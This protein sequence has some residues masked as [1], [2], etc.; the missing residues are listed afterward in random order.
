M[1]EKELAIVVER[2]RD[3]SNTCKAQKQYCCCACEL[4]PKFHSIAAASLF[5]MIEVQQW[6][7][8]HSLLWQ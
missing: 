6:L 3:S 5:Y 7:D 4:C 2:R 8:T 1:H